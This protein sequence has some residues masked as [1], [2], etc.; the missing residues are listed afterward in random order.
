MDRS[1]SMA[2]GSSG[3][4]IAPAVPDATSRQI[5]NILERVS[6]G[7]V[8]LNRDWRCTYVNQRA[9][10]LFG[11]R[12]EDLIGKHIW[13]EFPE[14]RGQPFHLAYEKAMAEQ[15][16]IEMENYY[17]PW[18]RWFENR[19]YPS[20]D[21]LSIFFHEIT[22][23]KQAE[24]AARESS[25]LL[26]GQN[27]TLELIARGAPLR[28]TLDFL[29]R[30][31]E[32]QCPGMLCSILLLDRDGVHVRHGAA[33]SLPE[34]YTHAIDGERIGPSAGSCGT[35]AFRK[36]PV[37]VEDIASDP[38]WDNYRDFALAHGLRACWSTPILDSQG[39]VLGTFALY[40][41][42]PCGPTKRHRDL[43]D[44]ATKT[45]AI[46]IVKHQE[47]EA[48][49]AS[50]ERL[51]LAVTGGNVGIWEW[52]VHSDRL[53]W[54]A[55]LKTMFGWP[56]AREDL[57][58]KMFLNAVWPEDRRRVEDALR[59]SLAEHVDCDVEFRIVPPDGSLRWIAGKGRG[60]YDAAGRRLRMMGIALDITDQKRAE[61]EINR[62]Q[63]QLA[64]A[65]RIAQLGSYEWDVRNNTVFRSEE[66]CRIFGLP[67]DQFAPTL[68]G[69]LERVHPEDRGATKETVERAFRE[70]QPFLFEERIVRPD[71]AIRLLRSQG[72]WIFD[73]AQQAAKL[74]G[75]CQDITERK[76]AE[77]QLR[78]SEERFQI[79][80]RATNDAIW[81]WDLASGAEWWNQGIATLFGYPPDAVDANIAWHSGNVHPGDLKRVASGLRA[82]MASGG[83]FW[84]AEYRFRRADASYADVFD[85][86]FVVYDSEKKPTRVIGAMADI[87]ER[88][89]AL[90]I[91]E[92]RV[93]VRTAELQERN[94]QLEC[95]IGQRKH[96]EDLLRS[97]NEELKGF[98]Y[99]VSHDLKAPLRGIAGYAQE[100]DRRHR[101]G[102]PD[103]ALFCLKQI[104]T[105]TNNLDRLIEDLLHYSRLDAE[106]PSVV[107][108]DLA[109]MVEGILKD[110]RPVILEQNAE[111]TVD[112]R[113][114][115]VS[116]W[117]RGLFQVLTNL[118]DNALKYSRNAAPPRIHLSSL[119][120]ADTF[121]ITVADNG[122]GFDM[123]YHD[124]I[125]G[126]FNRLVRQEEFEGTGAG[127]AIAKKVVEKLGG[128]IR[129]ESAPGAGA[130]FFV[131][132][133]DRRATAMGG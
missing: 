58:F 29:L 118:V 84:S 100:L 62:R 56:V 76:E 101:A 99:T 128:K 17:E 37:I 18:H 114:A 93:A 52:A 68:E 125:F 13:T 3:A 39:R 123:K 8:A 126:L 108:V 49:R 35:A 107:E 67:P 116:T 80:A 20:S 40:F 119:E 97:K 83:Q 23:R 44:L 47:T 75:I 82:V 120:L 92:Q 110:R 11:R 117:E 10:E 36:E 90:E 112:F 61:E 104:L 132:L 22:E 74:F 57:T 106:T 72:K 48:L 19:I 73:E 96:V 121:Q 63:A 4:R 133:P 87:S 1:E 94:D 26:K 33:P 14:G 103:R 15:V 59:R 81:D 54:S 71:G 60:D 5:G 16:F 65:Q 21:G 78:R 53:V 43:I 77:D 45:A 113:A 70:R 28:D 51:R 24:Q 66:L 98:A 124:R 95:E 127:L 27:E 89:R 122:I 109:G 38:L 79:V 6:D 86:A 30:F 129:A 9:A 12:P 46:A 32:A 42:T 31:I 25:R 85:R 131:E 7:F 55:E 115:K 105:A 102:L 2:D 111:V 69:Y 34:S 50:E 64:E 88:K 130:R 91:L 41:R